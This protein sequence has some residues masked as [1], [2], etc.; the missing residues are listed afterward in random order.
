[1]HDFGLSRKTYPA[2]RV[3]KDKIG[4]VPLCAVALSNVKELGSRRLPEAIGLN[5]ATDAAA[6]T[7]LF[8]N[9]MACC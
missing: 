9:S 5:Q 2:H 7:F 4:A 6:E 1:V 3:H 8:L